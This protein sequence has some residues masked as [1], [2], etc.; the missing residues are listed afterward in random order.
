MV[1]MLHRSCFGRRTYLRKHNKRTNRPCCVTARAFLLCA[2]SSD[3]VFVTTAFYVGRSV[4]Q[5]RDD[6]QT[7]ASVGL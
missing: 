1:R 4:C 2:S 5:K 3:V 6:N 7:R